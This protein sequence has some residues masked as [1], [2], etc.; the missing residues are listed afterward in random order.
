M[1]LKISQHDIM[2]MKD[3]VEK[4]KKRSS[5]VVEKS[6]ELVSTIV[7]TAE[8]GAAAFSMGLVQGKYGGVEIV[9]VPMDLGLGLGLHMMGLLGVGGNMSHHLHAFGDGTLAAYLTTLGRT[10]G[11]AWKIKAKSGQETKL[12]ST[13]EEHGAD[14]PAEQWYKDADGRYLLDKGGNPIRIRP[15]VSHPPEA[16]ALGP[17]PKSYVKGERLDDAELERLA[18]G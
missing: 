7:R 17:L 12:I 13:G 6:H 18:R 14:I 8:V 1:P 9:G 10:T 2:R 15:G 16:T 4:M 5:S 3:Q 11:Y